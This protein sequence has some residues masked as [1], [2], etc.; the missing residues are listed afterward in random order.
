MEPKQLFGRNAAPAK[1]AFLWNEFDLPAFGR[2]LRCNQRQ[3][4][5]EELNES[6]A[7]VVRGEN[8]FTCYFRR[9]LFASPQSLTLT[10][11]PAALG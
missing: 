9:I 8:Y 4:V 11:L 5:F 3:R 1:V 2:E 10:Q 7:I 6:A